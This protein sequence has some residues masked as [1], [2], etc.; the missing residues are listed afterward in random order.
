MCIRDSKNMVPFD[1]KSP[2]V[3][4]GVRIG[5][6]ALTT[7]GMGVDEVKTIVNL[8]DKVIVVNENESVIESVKQ[9]VKELCKSF[10]I[11]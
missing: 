7:R 8:I 2:F 6:P 4:S 3:T 11:Y 10:P 9:E 1:P 5:S